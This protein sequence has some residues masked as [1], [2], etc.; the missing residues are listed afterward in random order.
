MSNAAPVKNTIPLILVT[1]VSGAG[2]SSTMKILEDLGYEA[3]D[4][5]PVSMIWRLVADGDFS[6]PISIGIDIRTRGFEP[7]NF[8][9]ELDKLLRNPAIKLTLLFLDCDDKILVRRFEETRRQHP[10]TQGRSVSDG[11]RNERE[12]LSHVR[13]QSDVVIDTSDLEMK[14]LKRILKGHFAL[15][16][17]IGPAIFVTSFSFRRGLPRDADLVF[18]VRFLQNPY[19]DAELRT[20]T[21]RDQAVAKYIQQD[22]DFETFFDNLTRLVSPLIPRYAEEGKNYLTIAIGC[23][24]GHHRSVFVA[25]MLSVWL[26]RKVAQ[27]HLIHRDLDKLDNNN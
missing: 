7:S 23:T 9:E 26:N 4:N 3:V 20:L 8:L 21:G 2:K 12:Q 13:E 16:N 6:H 15:D 5:L 22:K 27:I 25:E 18:D 17:L 19:Y 1:G 14:D 11:L 24:G 10:L